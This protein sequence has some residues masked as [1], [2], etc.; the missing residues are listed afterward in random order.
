MKQSE[1]QEVKKM[2][3]VQLSKKV[4]EL[5]KDIAGLYLEKAQGKLTNLKVIQNRR[6][7]LAQTLTVK[8]QKRILEELERK[9]G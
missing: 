7:E 5:N 3:L 8:R 4:A 2:D 9:N 1:F 6:R